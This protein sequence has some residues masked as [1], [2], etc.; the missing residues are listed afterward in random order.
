MGDKI[1]EIFKADTTYIALYDHQNQSVHFP[2]YVEKDYRHQIKPAPLG[3]GLTSQVIRSRQPLLLGALAEQQAYH[4]LP[5]ILPGTDRDLNIAYLG[6]P[7]MS[8]DEVMGVVSVQSYQEHAYDEDDVRLLSTLAANM[9]VAIT[10]ARLFQAERL[11]ARRQA[12]LFRLSAAIAA[13]FD[14]SEICQRVVEGLQD[15]ALGY[16]YV[17]VYLVDRTTGDRVERA[18]V[19]WPQ[20]SPPGRLRP[21][22]G[23][24][25]RPLR[26]G[27]LHY[28]PNVTRAAGYVPSL[29]SGSEAD[30][31]I[32]IGSEVV[33]VLVVESEQPDAFDQDDFDVLTSAATQAGLAL[34]RARS[35]AETRQRV[36]ELATVN[37][38]SQALVSELDL[39]TLVE[40]VGEQIRQ[41]FDA[42]IVYVA[43]HQPETHLIY[44]PY[45]FGETLSPI[46]FG[47]GL[48]SKIIETGQPL[49]INEDIGSRHAELKTQRIGVAAKSY[50]G[51][52]INVRDE[53][54]GVISVQSTATEGRFDEADL[55]LLSTIAANVGIAIQNARLFEE[56][57]QAKVAA[58]RANQAKSTFLAN[59]SH[60]LRTPL[61]AIIG[62]SR[63]VQRKGAELLPEKQLENLDKVLIS[64]E[65]LLGLINTILDIAKIEAGRMQVQL[66]TFS[67]GPLL[68][69]CAATTE[70]LLKPEVKLVKVI[71]PDLPPLCSDQGK[72]RQILLNLLSNAAKF[73][74]SGQIVVAV[75]RG[76]A[77]GEPYHVATAPLNLHFSVSDTGI[78]IS[79]EA[80]GRIFEEFGQAD[81]S[82]TRQ[83]GGTG[84][85]LPISRKL[86]QLLG[87]NL[88]ATSTVGVGSTFSLTLPVEYREMESPEE[89]AAFGRS[90]LSTLRYQ[91]EAQP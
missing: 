50:L 64:A 44:F 7:M 56:T 75:G 66:G 71:E 41:T 38:V 21:G 32:K 11:Q 87:G 2:Y 39:A 62:F 83:Y 69:S 25:E 85:G 28:T 34:G 37:T 65:H 67:V 76:A 22:Q 43:L 30:V 18:S 88:A 48:T 82:T 86:A 36:A 60:E 81:G 24:S 23:L 8:G 35:L 6:V 72:V 51:V 49:L 70:P 68:E 57:E 55:R 14:E 74:H 73:T 91:Q 16:S 58:E 33:G 78:G 12:A 19:G 10:K 54:I 59:M 63:I 89:P 45:A 13:A 3:P 46:R 29:N 84:L 5:T 27:R 42:D 90:D 17:G 53:T 15:E 79:E 52:P 40:L 1:R 61:N 9:G 47:E 31:P 77:N 4:I 20:S 80:L 26:D